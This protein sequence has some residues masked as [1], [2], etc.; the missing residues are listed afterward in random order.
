MQSL[1][2][3]NSIKNRI[4]YLTPDICHV[5]GTGTTDEMNFLRNM[6]RCAFKYQIR[7]NRIIYKLNTLRTRFGRTEINEYGLW[8][9]WKLL[10]YANK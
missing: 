9:N 6:A 1:Y 3:Q 4:L 7:N 10:T 8:K 5:R 2:T